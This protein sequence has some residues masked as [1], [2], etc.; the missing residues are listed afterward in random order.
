[1]AR[2]N[3]ALAYAIVILMIVFV[4][5]YSSISKFHKTIFEEHQITSYYL[6]SDLEDCVRNCKKHN[7]RNPIKRKECIHECIVAECEKRHPPRKKGKWQ[8][9]YNYLDR[10][11]NN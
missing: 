2:N 5:I 11:F 7:T 6:T 9:C 10:I 1:M 8:A 3:L 4:I